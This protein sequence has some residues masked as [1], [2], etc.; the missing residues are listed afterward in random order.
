LP[1]Y[2]AWRHGSYH[3]PDPAWARAIGATLRLQRPGTQPRRFD[4]INRPDMSNLGVGGRDSRTYGSV[5]SLAALQDS[6]VAMGLGPDIRPPRH[7]SP[8]RRHHESLAL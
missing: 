1:R 4:L 7:H 3:N 2:W 5:T 6:I 8:R